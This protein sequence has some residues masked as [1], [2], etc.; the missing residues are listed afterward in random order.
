M[1][2]SVLR[3]R[4]R[5]RPQDRLQIGLILMI[6]MTKHLIVI[7][8]DGLSSVDFDFI[9]ELPHFQEYLR[10]ASYSKKVYSVYPSLTYPAHATIVTGKYP[11][12]HGVINNTLMQWNKVKPDWYWQRKFIKGDT[13]YD[14]A[15][16]NGM[17]VAALL[18]P[19]TA[20]SKIQF[21]M[22]EVVANRPWQNQILL[23]LFNGTPIYQFVLNQK[24]GH[25]R[26]GLKQPYL[27][28]FTH[29]SLLY[30]L[31]SKRPDLTLV[32]YVDLDSMRH[33]YGFH[34]IEARQALLRQDQRLGDIMQTLK[35]E[36]MY[37][38]STIIVLGDHSSLDEDKVIN[39]NV[40]LTQKGYLDLDPKGR[41][42]SYRAIAKSCDGSAYVYS[43]TGLI[44]E[45]RSL[46]EEFNRESNCLEAIYSNTEVIKLGADPYCSLM[47]EANKGYYFLDNAEGKLIDSVKHEQVGV[48]PHYT[49]AAHGYSPYKQDYTTVFIA[50]GK[51]IKEGITLPE[52]NLVDEAPTIAKL[53]GVKLGEADGRILEE[54]LEDI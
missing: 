39:L 15:I 30:T 17:K 22:P 18:W 33:Y 44:P 49:K 19:V 27:D 40:L 50:A 8:F 45:I 32:H 48:V 21:N 36:N 28:N 41:I 13:L 34:S 26:N 42:T 37:E 31:R 12:N 54:F 25:L 16:T 46:L 6:R 5:T 7:S 9:K 52:M 51:G 2:I 29:Q 23:S 14:L 10:K 3:E 38:E 1:P 20:K 47:L 24:F 4:V 11:K 53:L 35:E 43:N